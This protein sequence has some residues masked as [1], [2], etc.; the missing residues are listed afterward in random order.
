MHVV[1]DETSLNWVLKDGPHDPYIVVMYPEHFSSENLLKFKSSDRVSGVLVLKD[2]PGETVS[3]I[4]KFSTDLSCP[5]SQFSAYN[6]SN[7]NRCQNWNAPGSSLLFENFGFPIF[8]V[9]SDKEADTL[10][11]CYKDFN[12]P[13]NGEARD[14]P[15][16]AAQL[17]SFM[18]AAKDTPTCKRRSEA[19]SFNPMGCKYLL[20]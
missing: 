2:K 17:K 13:K 3:T 6:S 8:L 9:K 19:I 16:C 14:W 18:M 10:R 12:E 7:P 4:S 20:H 1:T 11:K 5:N 15:L